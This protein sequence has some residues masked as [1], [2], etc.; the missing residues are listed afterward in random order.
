MTARPHEIGF[1]APSMFSRRQ[2]LC[3][4]FFFCMLLMCI[5]YVSLP[6]SVFRSTIRFRLSSVRFI[7][8]I[9]DILF[10]QRAHTPTFIMKKMKSLNI[11]LWVRIVSEI[12]SHLM[13]ANISD[14][15]RRK[16]FLLGA[17]LNHQQY[18]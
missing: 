17:L 14:A 7:G 9:W 8:D 12:P 1:V 5:A 18:L 10:W 16:P 3:S 15:G 6:G 2:D 4:R 11:V 13:L